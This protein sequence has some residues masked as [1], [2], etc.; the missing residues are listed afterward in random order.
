MRKVSRCNGHTSGMVTVA[1][2]TIAGGCSA[3]NKAN[4]KSGAEG[5]YSIIKLCIRVAID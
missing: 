1:A 4:V 3:G 2:A 5:E